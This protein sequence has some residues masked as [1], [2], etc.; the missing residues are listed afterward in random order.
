MLGAF[1][2]ASLH[3]GLTEGARCSS[4][5][6]AVSRGILE[7][8]RTFLQHAS[9]RIAL[10]EDTVDDDGNRV[11]HVAAGAGN[12]AM[13]ELLL[14]AGADPLWTDGNGGLAMHDAAAEGHTEVIRL[15]VRRNTA[16]V[17][18]KDG[19]TGWTPLH[20][21]ASAGHRDT[22]LVLLAAL[23][24]LHPPAADGGAALVAALDKRDAKGWR[25]LECAAANGHAAVLDELLKAGFVDAPMSLLDEDDRVVVAQD[26]T[27]T[28][29]LNA[30][31]AV[32]RKGDST[33]L[34]ALQ[35]AAKAGRNA[36]C[37]HILDDLGADIGDVAQYHSATPKET[38]REI[39]G[40]RRFVPPSVLPLDILM[41][42]EEWL[43]LGQI[44]WRG[45]YVD[46]PLA[47]GQRW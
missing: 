11:L 19:T 22:C 28:T 9:D 27:F 4:L 30:S 47:P 15:L 23:R 41:T 36:V 13:C 44:R 10:L 42:V 32:S 43:P 21:A 26:A 17:A 24:S 45:R 37:L 38:L 39:F 14:D 8:A 16:Q 35:L 2:A 34:T 12:V 29:R 20:H 25:A 40:I 5:S 18:A 46:P 33:K 31:G 7:Q 6:D 3:R 1:G